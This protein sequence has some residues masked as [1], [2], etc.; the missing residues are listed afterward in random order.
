MLLQ[1]L[2]DSYMLMYLGGKKSRR[3]S[4]IK[5]DRSDKL[6]M[7]IEHQYFKKI[8]EPR[9]AVPLIYAEIGNVLNWL[10]QVR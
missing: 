7:Y 3:H 5:L 9:T 1:A 10:L 2:T 4:P 6:Y 8:Q